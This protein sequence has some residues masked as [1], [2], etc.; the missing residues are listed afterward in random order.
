ME[1]D[2]PAGVIASAKLPELGALPMLT[3]ARDLRKKYIAEAR[4]RF[5]RRPSERGHSS[6]SSSP[7]SSGAAAS[8]SHHP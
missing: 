7:S 4:G 6:S 1:W 5:S 2:R 8:R 3:E